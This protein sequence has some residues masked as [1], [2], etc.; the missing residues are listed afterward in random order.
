[1]TLSLDSFEDHIEEFAVSYAGEFY[2]DGKVPT[3]S[4][5]WC[6]VVARHFG[7]DEE[8][9]LLL[10]ASLFP[11]AYKYIGEIENIKRNAI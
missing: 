7:R 2:R 4:S 11:Y 9:A 6:G 10:Y 5:I 3:D 8:E 1:M